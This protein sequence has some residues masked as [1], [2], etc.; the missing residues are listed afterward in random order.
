MNLKIEHF[1]KLSLETFHSAGFR[2]CKFHTSSKTRQFQKS[3]KNF[4]ITILA[5]LFVFQTLA[6]RV[7]KWFWTIIHIIN[8][9][10]IITTKILSLSNNISKIRNF[11]IN[12]SSSWRVNKSSSSIMHHRFIVIRDIFDRDFIE[13]I[14]C[15]IVPSAF[16][17][18]L[19]YNQSQKIF[20][21]FPRLESKFYQ[22]C[23]MKKN[24][25][26]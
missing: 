2:L 12:W 7:Q 23:F 17:G 21:N 22:L 10:D 26:E 15:K 19:L 5:V 8:L 25:L 9:L 18:C 13:W 11:W 4:N 6:E 20:E 3:T 14:F 16:C 24:T 1:W